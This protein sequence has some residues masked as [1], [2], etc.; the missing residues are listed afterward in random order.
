MDLSSCLHDVVHCSSLWFLL[1]F[2]AHLVL[3][4]TKFTFPYLLIFLTNLACDFDFTVK[5]Q[6]CLALGAKLW[7][8]SSDFG[9]VL[10]SCKA[11]FEHISIYFLFENSCWSRPHLRFLSL[12]LHSEDLGLFFFSSGKIKI[13]VKLIRVDLLTRVVSLF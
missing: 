10:E 2:E 11:D 5:V 1:V 7:V 6:N 12:V 9:L 8:A 3:S 4:V 13:T